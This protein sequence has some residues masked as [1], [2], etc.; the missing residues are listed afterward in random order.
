MAFQHFVD[1]DNTTKVILITCK[2]L[3]I[4]KAKLTVYK[5][6]KH[7]INEKKLFL[8][9]EY[10]E[11]DDVAKMVAYHELMAFCSSVESVINAISVDLY[12]FITDYKGKP[13]TAH[14][15][16]E[17]CLKAFNES[18]HYFK[19]PYNRSFRNSMFETFNI[20]GKYWGGVLERNAIFAHFTRLQRTERDWRK[21]VATKIY[22]KISKKGEMKCT[23]AWS[24]IWNVCEK[25][26]GDLGII[27]SELEEFHTR[28]LPVDQNKRKATFF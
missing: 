8:K 9:H 24:E 2:F 14:K 27:L 25:T 1:A 4:V 17:L 20:S 7:V 12:K 6:Y 15:I 28:V 5:K 16:R 3:P 11:F 19:H 22:Q 18:Q 13:L 26:V 10:E 21:W 23:D